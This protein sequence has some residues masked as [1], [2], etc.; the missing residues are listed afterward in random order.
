MPPTLSTTSYSVLGLLALRD[1]TPYELAQQMTR[2]LGYVW[3]RAER[4]IY[5][6]PKRLVAAGYATA[7]EGAV[8]RR[9]RTTYSITPRGREALRAWLGTT[10]APAS[11]EIE[12]ALRVLFADQGD[13]EQLRGALEAVRDQAREARHD[14]AEMA[15]DQVA[16]D[17]GA[18]PERLHVNALAFRLIVEHHDLLGRWAEWALAETEGWDDATS[19]AETWRPAARQVFDEAREPR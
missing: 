19:P 2:T 17:G 13:L 8:G 18:F 3:P 1:W 16:D 4:R 15:D 5:D 9:R 14:L 11:L 7:E 10:P 6:E 12:G